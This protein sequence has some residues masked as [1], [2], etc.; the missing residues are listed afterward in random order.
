M[1]LHWSPNDIFNLEHADR[2]RFI[3]H[4][5]AMNRKMNESVETVSSGAVPLDQWFAGF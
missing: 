4:I 5:S 1:H 2:R 3:E